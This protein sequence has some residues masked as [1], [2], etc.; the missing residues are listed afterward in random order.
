MS[1]TPDSTCFESKRWVQICTDMLMSVQDDF[2]DINPLLPT[3][4][5]FLAKKAFAAI[6]ANDFKASLPAYNQLG[7]PTSNTTYGTLI[8]KW[9]AAGDRCPPKTCRSSQDLDWGND[10]GA[11]R[12]CV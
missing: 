7:R 2:G 8:L 5:M 3:H 12:H 6:I 11:L 1:T 9:L 4:Y 10:R